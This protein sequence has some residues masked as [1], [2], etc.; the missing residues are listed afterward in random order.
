MADM[1]CE[2]SPSLIEGKTGFNINQIPDV[3]AWIESIFDAAGKDVPDFEYTPQSISHLHNFAIR[4]Q[5]NTQAA[6]IVAN[7]LNQK[8][9]EYSSRGHPPHLHIVWTFLALTCTVLVFVLPF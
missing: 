7:D 3:K 2:T 8:A 5:A 9:A 4:S 6:L 1:I